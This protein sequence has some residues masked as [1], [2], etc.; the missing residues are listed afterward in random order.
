MKLS[1]FN[2]GHYSRLTLLL[3]MLGAQG[4]AAAHDIGNGHALNSDVCATCVIGNGLGTA[5][6][7]SYETPP[8]RV[9]QTH[10]P[11]HSIT[12]ALASRVNCHFARAPPL[13]FWNTQNPN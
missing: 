9:C 7:A 4:I 3:L 10:A 8:L 1:T 6:G 2:L 11:V 12:A 13:S 5:V